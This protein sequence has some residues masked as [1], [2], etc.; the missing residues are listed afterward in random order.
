MAPSNRPL[1]LVPHDLHRA[2]E[3]PEGRPVLAHVDKE[4]AGTRNLLEFALR[5]RDAAQVALGEE[6]AEELDQRLLARVPA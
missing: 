1:V 2:R 3:R 5:T 4:A 6:G